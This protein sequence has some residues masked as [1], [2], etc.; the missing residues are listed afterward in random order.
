MSRKNAWAVAGWCRLLAL[1]P[2]S[3]S[4]GCSIKKWVYFISVRS[5]RKLLAEV[6]RRQQTRL[7]GSG[8]GGCRKSL[9]RST[10]FSQS[11]WIIVIIS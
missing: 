1:D 9:T 7:A 3:E 6:N 4:G 10:N 8:E 11:K 5:G 2:I